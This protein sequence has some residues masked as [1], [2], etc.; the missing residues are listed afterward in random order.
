MSAKPPK[1]IKETLE[2]S[3]QVLDS[4]AICAGSY[5]IFFVFKA[6]C[7]LFIESV[8]GFSFWDVKWSAKGAQPLVALVYGRDEWKMIPVNLV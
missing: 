8:L 2:V 7:L 4:P 5:V 6:F 1:A 3:P